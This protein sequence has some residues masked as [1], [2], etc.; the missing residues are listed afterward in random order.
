WLESACLLAAF[1]FLDSK[2]QN[3]KTIDICYAT[4]A[5]AGFILHPLNFPCSI[6]PRSK[7]VRWII[8]EMGLL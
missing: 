4:T 1:T 3:G 2:D 6:A 8:Q 5:M 7:N